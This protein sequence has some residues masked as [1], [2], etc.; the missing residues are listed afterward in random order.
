MKKRYETPEVSCVA[1]SVPALLLTISTDTTAD[2]NAPMLS[3]RNSD[4]L[5]EDFLDEE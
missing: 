1:P 4:W 2:P 5:D 3:R